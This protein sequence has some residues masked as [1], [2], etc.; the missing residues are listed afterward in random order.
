MATALLRN[1]RQTAHFMFLRLVLGLLAGLIPFGLFAR[2]DAS[3]AYTV[4]YKKTPAGTFLPAPQVYWQVNPASLHFV[5]NADKTI[6]ASMRTDIIFADDEGI[7]QEDHFILNT[8]PRSNIQALAAL[9]I[10]EQR[11]YPLDNRIQGRVKVYMSITDINDT[12]GRYF[13]TDSFAVEGSAQLPFLSGIK[14]LAPPDT[15]SHTSL[16][17]CGNFLDNNKRILYYSF[18]LYNITPSTISPDKYPLTTHV[19]LSKKP[20]EVYLT[21]YT[22][23]DTFAKNV[24]A[25]LSGSMPIGTLTSGNYYI[26]ATLTDKQGITLATRSLFFQRMNTSPDKMEAPVVNLKEV[27]KDTAM[28]SVTVLNLDKTF[29]AKFN[30][31]QLRAILKMLLP[32]SDGMQTN[33]INGFL[34][35]PDEM[36]IKYF[37]YNHFQAINPKDPD[38]A[39]KEYAE[40]I[41]EVNKKFSAGGNAGYETDRGFIYL[42]YGKPTD[43]ITVTSEAGSLPYEVWQYNNLTQFGNNK[44][45]A[46]MLFLFYKQSQNLTDYRL[47]HST[48]P[49]ETN[50]LGWRNYLFTGNGASAAGFSL[51]SRADE[52]FGNR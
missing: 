12:T 28:E 42:R 7:L 48:V 16:P 45:L 26:N 10:L 50:N 30:M 41:K 20:A 46:N 24:P 44:E 5:T 38:K 17:L 35:K 49:G 3:V 13:F 1:L 40:I 51:N 6:T 25:I 18:D 33:T 11:Q 15:I 37:I 27:M 29:L 23:S 4:Y 31:V 19:R 22:V 36:Y 14:L 9:N 47:L 8:P 32:I 2:V 34:K 39:W 52:L 43:I 21:G